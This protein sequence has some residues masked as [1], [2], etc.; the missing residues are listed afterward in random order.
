MSELL[1]I[2]FY[3]TSSHK[4]SLGRV[5]Q[6]ATIQ[7]EGFK[8]F[9]VLRSLTTTDELGWGVAA[10][11]RGKVMAVIIPKVLSL[12]RFALGGPES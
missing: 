3:S 12:S 11:G 1:T 2:W 5:K 7:P 4:I 9:L 8:G 10:C 6:R